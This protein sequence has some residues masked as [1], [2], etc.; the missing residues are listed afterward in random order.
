MT[1]ARWLMQEHLGRKLEPWEHVDHKDEN[2]LND[3]IENYQILT[4][5][6]NTRKSWEANPTAHGRGVER[7]WTHGTV[8]GWMQKRCDC[9]VCGKARR[10]WNDARNE[11]R[12]KGSKKRGQYGRPSAHGE[13][14]HYRR[15]CRCE[16][17]RGANA[18]AAREQRNKPG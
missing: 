17:C 1:Y 14:L 6:E 9:E 15:G 10:E 16:E 18:A 2:R 3:L 12:R 4:L 11:Q 13:A 5:A 7:G 8:Y